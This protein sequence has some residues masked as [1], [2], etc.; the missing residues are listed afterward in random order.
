MPRF[1]LLSPF[2]LFLLYCFLWFCLGF[3]VVPASKSC[4]SCISSTCRRCNSTLNFCISS[5]CNSTQLFDGFFAF[6]NFP[7]LLNGLCGYQRFVNLVHNNRIN[8]STESSYQW[9]D[10]LTL[11]VWQQNEIETWTASECVYLIN[12][13]LRPSQQKIKAI[14]KPLGLK[15]HVRLNSLSFA[16]L[17]K[18]PPLKR[19]ICPP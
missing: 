9:L 7:D 2:L 17:E 4:R 8:W 11:L 10:L 6:W 1:L 15:V 14:V 5:T 3:P 18:P 16:T 12:N 13:R 19:H